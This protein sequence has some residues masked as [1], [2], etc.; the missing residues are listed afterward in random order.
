M[1]DRL[2]FVAFVLALAPGCFASVDGGAAYVVADLEARNLGTTVGGEALPVRPVVLASGEIE[3]ARPGTPPERLRIETGE[4]IALRG[5][6]IVR[7]APND[8]RPDALSIRA[9]EADARA[10]AVSIG[11]DLIGRGD[12]FEVAGPDAFARAAALGSDPAGVVEM[13][14]VATAELEVAP[15]ATAR[16]VGIDVSAPEIVPLGSTS[17]LEAEAVRLLDATPFTVASGFVLAFDAAPMTPGRFAMRLGLES[18]SG[19][20]RGGSHTS[21]T[22]A[23]ALEVAAD[24]RAT[25]CGSQTSTSTYFS[26]EYDAAGLMNSDSGVRATRVRTGYRGAWRTLE[27]GAIGVALVRDDSVCA[28]LAEGVAPRNTPLLLRCAAARGHDAT[29]DV[30]LPGAGLACVIVRDAYSFE[31]AIDGVFLYLGGGGGWDVRSDGMQY[32]TALTVVPASAPIDPL[33]L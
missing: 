12:L 27:D 24:G 17:P 15:E 28:P 25:A 2:P 13:T 20:S 4:V 23:F 16:V 7:F 19:C 30:R 3:I 11:A 8:V 31:P 21:A 22:G 29:R 32:T 5:A 33:A 14:P 1:G 18:E 9:P 26:M 10:L 6:R